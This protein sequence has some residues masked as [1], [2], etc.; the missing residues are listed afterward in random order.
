MDGPGSMIEMAEINGGWDGGCSRMWQC[1]EL[2][3][4][5]MTR[6]PLTAISLHLRP[7]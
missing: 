2:P 1:V 5:S 3:G 6:M 7:L 4:G